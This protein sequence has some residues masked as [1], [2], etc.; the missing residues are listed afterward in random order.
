MQNVRQSLSSRRKV[1]LCSPMAGRLPPEGG[2]GGGGGRGGGGGGLAG[3]AKSISKDMRNS[4]EGA[5]GLRAHR[6]AL[7]VTSRRHTAAPTAAFPLHATRFPECGARTGPHCHPRMGTSGP[8]YFDPS[9]YGPRSHCSAG[10]QMLDRANLVALVVAQNGAEAGF[11]PSSPGP[12]RSCHQG[13]F[14]TKIQTSI[15]RRRS[16]DHADRFATMQADAID[17]DVGV[18]IVLCIVTT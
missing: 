12:Q 7:T 3:S 1:P 4:A 6:R 2:G 13:Q 11:K 18:Q 9:V 10:Q 8:V 17:R 15:R 14:A 5:Q 16:Q